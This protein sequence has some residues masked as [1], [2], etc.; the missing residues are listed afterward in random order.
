MGGVGARAGNKD[1]LARMAHGGNPVSEERFCPYCKSPVPTDRLI[2][3][4]CNRTLP[5][6]ELERAVGAVVVPAADAAE[7]QPEG[8]GLRWGEAEGLPGEIPLSPSRGESAGGGQA[9]VGASALG[10]PPP[11][12]VPVPPSAGFPPAT[13]VPPAS[14]VPPPLNAWPGAAAGPAPTGGYAPGEPRG[15]PPSGHPG[16]P[17]MGPYVPPAGGYAPPPPPRHPD[18]TM[19]IVGFILALVGL[20]LSCCGC[21]LV[22]CPVGLILCIVSHTRRPT[23]LSLAGIIIGSVGTLLFVGW[24]IWSAYY[25]T[26]PGAYEQ[27]LRELFDQMGMPLPPGF[28]GR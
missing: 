15:M 16:V 3:P 5:A 27:I 9:V 26:H 19:G 6:P 8:E 13:P 7:P 2:C 4:H 1:V 24:A 23:G 10:G 25:L 21:T 12:H 17:P 28:P 11:G 14:P 20:V 22:L 18:E